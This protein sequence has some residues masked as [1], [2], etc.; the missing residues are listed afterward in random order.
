M[1]YCLGN[2]DNKN[3]HVQCRHSHP[4]IFAN[5]FNPWLVKSTNVEPMDAEGQLY[6]IFNL[7]G[8]HEKCSHKNIKDVNFVNLAF[9]K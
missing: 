4:C 2:N 6:F 1:Q 5:M 9:S 8:T 7:V 3:V